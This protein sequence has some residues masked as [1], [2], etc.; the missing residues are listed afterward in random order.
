MAVD[1]FT[2]GDGP[3]AT[4][5]HWFEQPETPVEPTHCA[6]SAADPCPNGVQWHL[7][8]MQ[9]IA[10]AETLSRLRRVRHLV[11]T[12]EADRLAAVVSGEVLR[13]L[14]Q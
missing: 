11:I 4:I 8:A 14:V 7:C 3:S 1:A 12:C 2:N 6:N 9:L 5:W 13:L 10:T